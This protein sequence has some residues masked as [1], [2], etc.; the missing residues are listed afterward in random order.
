MKMTFGKEWL[1]VAAG[2]WQCS[3]ALRAVS[4]GKALV[5]AFIQVNITALPEAIGVFESPVSRQARTA[6]PTQL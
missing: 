2:F 6:P 1:D 5:K 3:E 4:L